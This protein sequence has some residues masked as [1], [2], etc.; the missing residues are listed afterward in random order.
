MQT[1]NIR[2]HYVWNC[3]NVELAIATKITFRVANKV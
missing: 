2:K 3:R 1:I